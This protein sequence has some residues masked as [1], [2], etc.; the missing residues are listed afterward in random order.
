[1][2]TVPYVLATVVALG[3]SVQQVRLEEQ[4]R[5]SRQIKAGDSEARVMEVLGHPHTR[6]EHGSGLFNF[7][8]GPRQWAYGTNIDLGEI[9]NAGAI[10]PNLVPFKLRLFGPDKGDLVVTWNKQGAVASVERH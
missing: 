6:W 9:I 5:A 10:F 1:M 8:T 2:I 7:G 3:G 4:V